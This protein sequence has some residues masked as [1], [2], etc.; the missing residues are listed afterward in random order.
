MALDPLI[1]LQGNTYVDG[2]P[3]DNLTWELDHH[4]DL[5]YTEVIEE[6]NWEEV[7]R[8]ADSGPESD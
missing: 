1:S 4:A 5:V 7:V 3:T 6:R 2:V 8:Y